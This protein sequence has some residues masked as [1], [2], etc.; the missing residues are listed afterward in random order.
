MLSAP[1]RLHTRYE[2]RIRHLLTVDDL[3]TDYTKIISEIEKRYTSDEPYDWDL[4]GEIYS[5]LDN[6]KEKEAKLTDIQELNLV[7]KSN[8]TIVSHRM[9]V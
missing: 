4:F 9:W 3:D 5:A 8:D 6:I 2:L 7:D 1:D